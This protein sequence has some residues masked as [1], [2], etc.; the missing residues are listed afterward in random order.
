MCC[1]ILWLSQKCVNSSSMHLMPGSERDKTLSDKLKYAFNY[2][3]QNYPSYGLKLV[4]ETFEHWLNQ[5]IKIHKVSKVV[6]NEQEF[7]IIILWVPVHCPLPSWLNAY[8]ICYFYFTDNIIFPCVLPNLT[9]YKIC[10]ESE[11]CRE[12]ERER[13]RERGQ[14]TVHYSSPQSFIISFFLFV[15][16]TNLVNFDWL[17]Y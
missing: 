12:R 3:T 11:A 13:E 7:V 10:I 4:V 9:R 15:G 5:Q 6:K 1:Q 8:C 17:I 14:W 16:L 2:N